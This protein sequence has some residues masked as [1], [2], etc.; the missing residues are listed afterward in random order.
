MESSTTGKV[1]EVLVDPNVG[2][3]SLYTKKKLERHIIATKKELEKNRLIENY[4]VRYNNFKVNNNSDQA[5]TSLYKSA[6]K[7]DQRIRL[8]L[9]NANT[10]HSPLIVRHTGARTVG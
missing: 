6:L 7:K 4:H 2:I 9:S 3:E 1:S 8:V 10:V 5:N